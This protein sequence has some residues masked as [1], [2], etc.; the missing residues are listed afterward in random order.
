[1][2]YKDEETRKAVNAEAQRKRRQGVTEVGGDTLGVTG[3]NIGAIIETTKLLDS[4][5]HPRLTGEARI[6]HIQSVLPVHI[7]RDIEKACVAVPGVPRK[8]R[9]D[10]AMRYYEHRN[11]GV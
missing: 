4:V 11:A 9:Y 1:M 7:V 3:D 10:N 5:L 8:D 6:K 2:P